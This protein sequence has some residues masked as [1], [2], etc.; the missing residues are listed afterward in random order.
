LLAG[1]DLREIA[2]RSGRSFNTVRTHL[3]RLL[4]KTDTRR[5]SDLVRL[6]ARL[7]LA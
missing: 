7:P 5:Q 1:F 2:Q 4:A 3:A 6:L